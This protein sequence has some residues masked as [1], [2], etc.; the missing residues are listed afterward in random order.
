M[1]TG[2]LRGL[3]RR[4]LC[5]ASVTQQRDREAAQTYIARKISEGKTRREV[6]RA[7]K[8]LANR[9]IRRMWNDERARRHILTTC[10]G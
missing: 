5:V 6:R 4:P 9:V 3:R 2:L 10:A 8:H 1:R 7:H